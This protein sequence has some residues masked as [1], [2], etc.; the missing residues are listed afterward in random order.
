L[1][2]EQHFGGTYCLHFQGQRVSQAINQ[3]KL[4]TNWP[5]SSSLKMEAI[6]LQHIRL[7]LSYMALQPSTPN[8]N[9][10]LQ[11]S[12]NKVVSKIFEPKY[13][14]NNSGYYIIGN[15]IIY[16]GHPVLL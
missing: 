9:S 2:T 4:I 8:S 16:T 3:K 1:A 11:V 13:K 10:K 12:E 6:F 15:F 7:S 14:A 5:Y